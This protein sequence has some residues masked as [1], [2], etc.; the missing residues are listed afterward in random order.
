MLTDPEA[1]RRRILEEQ[2]GVIVD[3][4]IELSEVLLKILPP[5]RV[6]KVSAKTCKGFSELHDII[7]ESFCACGDLT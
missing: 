3:L 1:L 5:A 6:V 7:Q 4:A 2:T